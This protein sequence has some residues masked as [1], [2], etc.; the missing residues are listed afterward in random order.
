MSATGLKGLLAAMLLVLVGVAV[1]NE[2]ARHRGV[3]TPAAAAAGPRAVV[4]R[5]PS[6]GPQN[7]PGEGDCCVSNFTPGCADPACS[8]LTSSSRN[9]AGR[10]FPSGRYH[11]WWIDRRFVDQPFSK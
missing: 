7:C 4:G 5:A 8:E 6:E 2:L 10:L 1:A 9:P 11:G 3:G